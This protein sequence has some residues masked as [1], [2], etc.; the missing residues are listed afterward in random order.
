M[1]VAYPVVRLREVASIERDAIQPSAIPAGGIF[2]GL[3]NVNASGH[4]VGARPVAAGELM[5]PKFIFTP[6]HILYGKLRPN[7]RKIARPDFAG[8][9]STDILPVLPGPRIER[10]FLFHYLRRPELTALAV[11]RCSGANLPRLSPGIL[12]DFPVHLPTMTEQRRI[13]EILNRAEAIVRA[14][15]RSLTLAEKLPG[16]FFAETFGAGAVMKW[17]KQKLGDLLEFLTSGS[18]GWGK[19]YSTSGAMFLRIQN[20]GANNLDFE[21]IAHVD[22]PDNAEARRTE[23]KP[24]DVLLSITAD[25]GRT[26]VYP[27]RQGRAFINQH[28]AILRTRKLEPVFL[29]GFLASAEG[30]RQVKRLNKV[31]VKAGLNFDDIRSIVVPMPPD[32]AQNRYA[33]FY[34]AHGVAMNRLR[35]A[36]DI[37]KQVVASQMHEFFLD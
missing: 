22:P 14:R 37:S 29:S 3:G 19:Y 11:R 13:V 20:V 31:G 30:Q 33:E 21:D 35:V 34:R 25:L 2:V 28:L 27:E 24:G 12:A 10:E 23:V 18:R 32:Q 1:K 7:L 16:A 17:R 6:Q 5:S 9:C 26:G 36:L 4:I 8:Y 15:E